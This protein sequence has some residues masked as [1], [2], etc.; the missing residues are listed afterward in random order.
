MITNQWFCGIEH[1]PDAKMLRRAVFV[2]EQG[3]LEEEEIDVLDAQAMHAVIYDGERPVATGRVYHD[4][5]TFCIG[6]ICV[7]K[8]ARG[9][10][11]GDLLVKLLLVKAFEFEPSQVRVVAQERVKGFYETFGFEVCG[12][13]VDDSGVPHVPM[14]VTKETLVFRSGCGKEMRFADIF[15]EK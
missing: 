11:I 10:G 6:R 12:E 9:Q 7:D 15:P 5:K 4:G 1:A 14:S 13:Q 8:E 2:D 3:F